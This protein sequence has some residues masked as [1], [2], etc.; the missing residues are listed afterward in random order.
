M[1]TPGLYLAVATIDSLAPATRSVLSAAERQKIDQL[2]APGRIDEYAAGR[3]LLRNLLEAVTGVPA[4]V[5]RISVTE[6]GKPV[7]RGGPGISISH[8]RDMVV[9][10]VAE[11][12][13]VGVDIEF[14]DSRRDTGRL[15]RRFFSPDESE[16]LASQPQDRFYML[17]VL[18]EAWLKAIG[19]GVAGGLDRLQCR[20]VP[21]VIDVLGNMPNEPE[22]RLFEMP[23]AFLAL[24]AAEA[25]D[26]RVQQWDP[27][28][29]KLVG[30]DDVREIA[31]RGGRSAD[32]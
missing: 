13:E 18:K 15:A 12:G 7:C 28:L 1:P 16:W 4:A 25:G 22:L 2:S 23:G 31:R 21:P 20:V 29:G 14:L 10:A 32:R 19:T 8:S 11:T 3:V 24:A 5:H 27:S 17:W 30:A 26:T 6:K 9:C